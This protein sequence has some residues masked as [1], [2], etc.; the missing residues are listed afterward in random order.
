MRKMDI[1]EK[2]IFDSNDTEIDEIY[3]KRQ[4]W[5]REQKSTLMTEIDQIHKYVQNLPL[6]KIIHTE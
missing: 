2:S 6:A 4:N 3:K 5:E 1:Q